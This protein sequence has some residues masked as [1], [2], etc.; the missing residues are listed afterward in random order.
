VAQKRYEVAYNRYVIGK[1]TNDIL[2]LS[3]NDKDQSLLS[4]VLALRSYWNSYYRL[5]R[6]TLYDF[7]KGAV[8]R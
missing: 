3:Q 5:R 1:I 4:Y 6:L 2:Y 7:E 8:I